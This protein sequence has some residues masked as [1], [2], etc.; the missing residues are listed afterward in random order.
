MKLKPLALA[1]VTVTAP[2]LLLAP[3]LMPT[4][5]PLPWTKW[6]PTWRSSNTAAA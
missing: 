4:K 3:V 6:R 1:T 5:K 2:S